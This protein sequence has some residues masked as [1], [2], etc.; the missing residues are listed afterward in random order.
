MA[1]YVLVHG[2]AGHP[3]HW[4]LLVLV[5]ATI[6]EPGERAENWWAI[7]RHD[8]SR[9]DPATG[10]ADSSELDHGG[11]IASDFFHDLAPELTAEA[12]AHLREQSG[13]PFDGGHF[14]ALS[15]PRELADRLERYRIELDA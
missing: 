9:P 11:D 3:W 8:E 10:L 5:N 7:T 13:T 4:H 2:A 6:P 12:L 1:T 15:R 14:V